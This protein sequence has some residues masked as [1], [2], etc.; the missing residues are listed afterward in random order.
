MIKSLPILVLTLILS[1][2]VFS[3]SAKISG[4]IND[5]ATKEVL[6]GVNVIITGTGETENIKTGATTDFDGKYFIDLPAGNYSVS[7][8]Y[9]GYQSEK[10]NISLKAGENKLVNIS[11]KQK[12]ELIDEV[13]VSAGKFEQ[14]LTDV[15]VTMEVIK[16]KMIENTN[17]INMESAV[18][19]IVGVDVSDQQLS[20]R[21]SSGWSYGA[22]S[23][24]ILLMDDLPIMSPDAGDIKWNYI[25]LEN[26][27]QVEVVK[28]AS[29]A[30]YGS[31]A[32]SGV[33]NIRSAYPTDKPQTSVS[34][35]VGV[36]GTPKTKSYKWWDDNFYFNDSLFY[37]SIPL[38]NSLYYWVTN[39]MYSGLNLSHSQQF[40]NL[41]LSFGGNHFVNEG[42]RE[43]NYET[44]SRVNLN[45]RYRCKKLEGL[46]FGMNSN[47]MAQDKSDFFFWHSDTM[48]L[49]TPVPDKLF[50]PSQGFRVNIDPFIHYYSP[51]GAIYKIKSRY[52][53][54]TQTIPNDTSKN[55]LGDLYYVEYIY[56]KNIKKNINITAGGVNAYS[57]VNSNLFGEHYSNNFSLYGQ[58]DWS[59]GRLK[60]SLGIR[61]EYFKVDTAQTES[62]VNIGNFNIPF[63]PVFRAGVN[64]QLFEHTYLRA[65]FGQ[66]YRFPSISEKYTASDLGGLVNL[67]PNPYLQPENGWSTEIGVKQGIKLWEGW[68]GFVDLS[69]FMQ[70]IYDMIE[71][72]IG[73]Y[74]PD[75]YLPLHLTST[76]A[77]RMFGFQARNM[78][79][80]RIMGSELS[81]VTSGKLGQINTTVMM[82]YTYNN[83]LNK[84]GA[85]STAS[86][87]HPMLKYRYLHS[88]KGDIDFEAKR[89]TFGF[90]WI[91]NSPMKNID[92]LFCD[93]RNPDDLQGDDLNL[94]NFSYA[95]SNLFLL[96]GYFDYRL[97]HADQAYISFDARLGFR[98]NEYIR[99]SLIVKN[100]FNYEY[101]G[102]PADLRPPRRFEIQ[103]SAKF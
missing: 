66:G 53:G 19:Q 8:Q 26:I 101:V 67:M 59:F 35:F 40:G 13:V 83:P 63:K 46:A 64:Y 57:E 60:T 74:D 5:Q 65:S 69:F 44:R 37:H 84:A 77:N 1:I 81:V 10:R 55:S 76:Q 96:P 87:E 103:V 47:F 41:D 29:S 32:L 100:I 20:I 56:S 94:Y 75:T 89:F 14:K 12:A 72:T 42:Y 33:I 79:D 62:L 22:G 68:K 50:A 43:K 34:Y 49:N 38:R 24:V 28:G 31:S 82:G 102:R 4:T 21:S 91:Y 80:A 25:P 45:W 78:G 86:T 7:F 95:L 93:E 71:F 17:T 23:R 54:T 70:E 73:M 18:N 99:T 27:S 9:I 88:F 90:N 11:L 16:P 85:D 15:T 97:A 36:Y 3:Q 58:L 2:S 48:P 39:P 52:F 98:F 51:K 92:R 6:Y 30:L 61:G